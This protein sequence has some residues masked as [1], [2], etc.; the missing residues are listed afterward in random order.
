MPGSP[1]PKPQREI[2]CYNCEHRF[3]VAARAMRVTCPKCTK[4][5]LLDDI[6]VKNAQGVSKMQTCG[7]I[8]VRRGGRVIAQLVEADQ[9]VEVQGIMEGKVVS[10]GPVIVGTRA[11]WK[12]D[13]TAPCVDIRKGAKIESGFFDIGPHVE[14]TMSEGE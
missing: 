10:R 14:G 8:T 3:E 6:V 4:G 12:G 9:G 7:K 13:L 2:R 1:P 11:Q 5:V